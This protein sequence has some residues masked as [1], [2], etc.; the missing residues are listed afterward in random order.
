MV[1]GQ[2]VCYGR[3]REGGIQL[4]TSARKARTLRT[5]RPIPLASVGASPPP[6]LCTTRRC[7]DGAGILL[8]VGPIRGGG[9]I[10]L[11]GDNCG[12]G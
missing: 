9:G 11:P 7:K 6:S 12:R 5:P 10:G 3:G 2:W 4:T 8:W 1:N